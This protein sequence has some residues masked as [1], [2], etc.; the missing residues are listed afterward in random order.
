MGEILKKKKR[1]T[2]EQLYFIKVEKEKKKS[3][4]K[5]KVVKEIYKTSERIIIKFPY[6]PRLI[7]KVR[8][9]PK[10]LFDPVEKAWWVPFESVSF[11]IRAFENEGFKIDPKVYELDRLSRSLRTVVGEIKGF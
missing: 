2:W 10:R 4:N 3:K 9:I 8:K 6:E 7:E 5:E 1:Q 11:V